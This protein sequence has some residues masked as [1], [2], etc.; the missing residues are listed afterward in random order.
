MENKEQKAKT[1][2]EENT[3]LFSEEAKE[4]MSM[5]V[6]KTLFVGALVYTGIVAII[7]IVCAFIK[8]P[9]FITTT[10]QTDLFPSGR[11]IYS[12]KTGTVKTITLPTDSVVKDGITIIEF[13]DELDYSNVL[14]IEDQIHKIE[15]VH[16]EHN[17]FY[18]AVMSIKQYATNTETKRIAS[19]IADNY[20]L[21]NSYN[22][23][24]DIKNSIELKNKFENS[25][26]ELKE[27]LSKW[28]STNTISSQFKKPS[29]L[30]LQREIKNGDNLKYNEPLGYLYEEDAEVT[31]YITLNYEELLKIHRNQKV[32]LSLDLFNQK[33]TFQTEGSVSSISYLPELNNGTENASES[34]K[35]YV[36]LDKVATK[37]YQAELKKYPKVIGKARIILESRS[38]LSKLIFENRK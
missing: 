6:N 13:D 22:Q 5:P 18:A 3:I 20:V 35:I 32:L 37:L 33:T 14:K 27:Y 36:T 31:G 4:L 17:N 10:F 8:F 11:A 38:L 29:K 16:S 1:L 7:F 23:L 2:P 24:Q 9:E 26:A 28:K 19:N 21:F 15:T 34:Y 30:F 25:I 12:P